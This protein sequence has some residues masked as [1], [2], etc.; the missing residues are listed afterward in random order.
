MRNNI[1]KFAD[2]DMDTDGTILLTER[3]CS[4]CE[5]ES[6]LSTS[7]LGVLLED[8]KNQLRVLD[9]VYQ[10]RFRDEL[11]KSGEIIIA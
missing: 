5:G 7:D 10:Q 4:C 9:T 11:L 1:I 2:I 3:G 6:K 8:Y